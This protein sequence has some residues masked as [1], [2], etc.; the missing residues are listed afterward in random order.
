MRG[1]CHLP[2]HDSYTV[3]HTEHI[4]ARASLS[5]DEKPFQIQIIKGALKLLHGAS[6][7]C[8][9]D[10]GYPSTG[11]SLTPFSPD[12]LLEALEK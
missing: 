10:M 11:V 9:E 1:S 8:F 6:V 12:A 3:T 7:P 2:C 5:L 4:I